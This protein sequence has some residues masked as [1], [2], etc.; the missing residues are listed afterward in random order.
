MSGIRFPSFPDTPG[1]APERRLLE[2]IH[3]SVPSAGRPSARQ[4]PASRP[5]KVVAAAL[6]LQLP[7]QAVNAGGGQAGQRHRAH[8]AVPVPGVGQSL[9]TVG[10]VPAGRAGGAWMTFP[11]RRTGPV[12]PYRFLYA[13]S[14]AS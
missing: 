6:P 13:V 11:F 4:R 12:V 1:A 10:W 3:P 2:G 8:G 9:G 7:V 14:A 5:A